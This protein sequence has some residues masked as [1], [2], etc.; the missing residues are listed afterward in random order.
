MT[1]SKARRLNGEQGGLRQFQ[2]L[3]GGGNPNHEAGEAKAS[4]ANNET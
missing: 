1:I 4:H 2:S 3:S